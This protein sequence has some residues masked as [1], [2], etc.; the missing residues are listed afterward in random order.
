[1]KIPSMAI[2]NLQQGGS[3][4]KWQTAHQQAKSA[5]RGSGKIEPGDAGIWA[6]CARSQERRASTELKSMLEEVEYIHLMLSDC[7]L[8]I[9]SALKDSMV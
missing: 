4:G 5:A 6:T 8:T 1:M 7:L 2:S 3:G 9:G